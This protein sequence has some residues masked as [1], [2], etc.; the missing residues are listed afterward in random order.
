MGVRYIG[1][2]AR[3]ANSILEI[4]GPP[5]GNGRF[6]DAF[7]GTGV[8]AQAAADLGWPVVINDFMRSSVTLASA[9]LISFP[10]APFSAFGGYHEAIRRLNAAPPLQGFF[11]R[12]YSPESGLVGGI[13]RRY[14]TRENASRIDGVRLAIE[15]WRAS[16][17]LNEHEHTLLL[18]DLIVSANSV[19]NI[20]GT[21]GCFLS[22]WTESAKRALTMR[23]RELRTTTVPFEAVIGDVFRLSS[24]PQDVVYLDPPY[25]K[26]QYASYYHLLETLVI[27]D[28]PAVEGVSGLRPWKDRSS[29]FCYKRR[30]LSAILRLVKQTRSSRIL[31]SYSNEGHVPQSELISGLRGIGE[32]T[33]HPM[34]N[35]GRYRPNAV[36][37]AAGS[38]VH[39]FVIEILPREIASAN[40]EPLGA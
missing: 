26:R 11:F 7:C 36:A 29:D 37:S 1:S 9:G 22:E 34:E 39:E 40:A 33:L 4:A 27:G 18:G 17:L 20:S 35:I 31:L 24:D 8:V 14:F 12:E 3:I 21:Y 30:A 15:E 25:T 28:E 13:E 19:A 10:Q 2:K 38:H 23:P 6:V 5:L 32:V 16:G